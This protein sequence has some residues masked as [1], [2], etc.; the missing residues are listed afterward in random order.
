MAGSH[1]SGGFILQR[2]CQKDWAENS[3]MQLM[4]DDLDVCDAAQDR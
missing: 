2:Y 4:V 3:M 1:G